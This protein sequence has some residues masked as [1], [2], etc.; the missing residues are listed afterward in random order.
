MGRGCG[1][2]PTPTADRYATNRPTPPPANTDTDDQQIK[3]DIEY[4]VESNQDADYLAQYGDAEE[5]FEE[6]YGGLDIDE[7]PIQITDLLNQVGGEKE[8]RAWL[9]SWSGLGSCLSTRGPLGS[10]IVIIRHRN[11]YTRRTAPP[12]RAHGRAGRRR[13]AAATTTT[14]VL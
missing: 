10:S 4:F 6:L 3:D 2:W 8:G 9:W 7:A 14:Y 13:A 12:R 11:I 5:A 1:R